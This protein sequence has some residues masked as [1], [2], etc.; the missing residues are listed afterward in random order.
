M[1]RVY[2]INP[3]SG[4]KPYHYEIPLNIA[5]LAACLEKT[6]DV[7]IQVIDFNLNGFCKQRIEDISNSKD[8]IICI[9]VYTYVINES[10]AIIELLKSKNE[11]TVIVGGPHISLR[12]KE[13]MEKYANI[14]YGLSGE[15]DYTLPKLIENLN[16]FEKNNKDI[17]NIEGLIYRNGKRVLENKRPSRIECLDKL[18]LQTD[19]FKYFDLNL[20][21]NKI[22]F[23][24][25][26]ASR[27]C[28][29]NCIYC[30]SSNL[31]GGKLKYVAP[32]IVARE[33]FNIKEMGFRIIN[34]RD[35]FFTMNRKWLCEFLKEIKNLKIQWG[36]ETR[37]DFVDYE[38]LKEMREAGCIL[39]RFGIET[40]NQKSLNLIGKRIDS[41]L[42]LNNLRTVLGM[43]FLEVRAS[44]IIG[45]PFETHE[46]IKR[47]IDTCRQLTGLNLKCRFFALNPVIG[48]KLY[49][50]MEEYK[51]KFNNSYNATHS[52]IETSELSNFDI[53]KI[54]SD[55]Y[56]EFGNP[57]DYSHR[58][59]S[60]ILSFKD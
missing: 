35:D 7:E 47:T 56:D 39:I 41:N 3:L 58:D 8:N 53:N 44:F 60:T 49:D 4:L 30:S 27:G 54:L 46:D 23:V 11:I 20:I 50:S 57:N 48:T 43:G 6:P 19:G 31:W 21:K 32:Q 55:V 59:F 22:G 14:T 18:P 10:V 51:I 37:I 13:F 38:I 29:Y 25:Y 45:I 24:P 42:I 26:I 17:F 16:C 12:G 1:K 15:G 52:N 33:I 34:F 9:P 2:F 28:C 36:C 5:Q 40:F